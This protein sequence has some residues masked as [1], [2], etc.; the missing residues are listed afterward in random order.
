MWENLRQTSAAKQIYLPTHMAKESVCQASWGSCCG[1]SRYQSWF[2][3]SSA[4]GGKTQ[5][6][7][8]RAEIWKPGPACL[9]PLREEPSPRGQAC[10]GC[11]AAMPDP[12]AALWAPEATRAKTPR[13]SIVPMTYWMQRSP[14]TQRGPVSSPRCLSK[15]ELGPD[16]LVL[17]CVL[18]SA[19]WFKA[20]ACLWSNSPSHP[21][22]LY[23]GSKHQAVS[24]DMNCIPFSQS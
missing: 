13:G 24:E 11:S 16:W 20:G 19:F 2:L 1:K 14:P 21:R 10:W 17:M 9:L 7:A 22:L 5:P 4:Q 3:S 6:W 12:A 15:P 18:K 8:D 23:L